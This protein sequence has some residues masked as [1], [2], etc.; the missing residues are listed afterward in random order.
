MES[1][2]QR[3]EKIQ[4][5]RNISL[6][7][8]SQIKDK[9]SGIIYE[10]R[11]MDLNIPFFIKPLAQELH[12]LKSNFSPYILKYIDDFPSD[13]YQ[14]Y[15]VVTE[16]APSSL[17][18][19]IQQ[20]KSQKKYIEEDFVVK[21]FLQLCLAIGSLHQRRIIIRNLSIEN[22]LLTQGKDVRLSNFFLSK[23]LTSENPY[24]DMKCGSFQNQSPEMLDGKPYNEKTDIWSLG[25]I[26]YELLTLMFPF[27]STIPQDQVMKAIRNG[28]YYPINKSMTPEVLLILQSLL[29]PDAQK[30]P[31]IKD[32]LNN[33]FLLSKASS[34]GLLQE[35]N[36]FLSGVQNSSQTIGGNIPTP[37]SILTPI[38]NGQ[39]PSYSSTGTQNPIV[40]PQP[41]P[42]A[43][44]GINEIYVTYYAEETG[45]AVNLLG[46]DCEWFNEKNCIIFIDQQEIQFHKQYKFQQ[47]GLH[48]MKLLKNDNYHLDD[49]SNMFKNCEDI[50]EIDGTNWHMENVE[51]I[52]RMFYGCRKLKKLNI[53]NWDTHNIHEMES[54]FEE[55][56]CLEHLNINFWNVE[57]VRTMNNLFYQ[58]FELKEM[59]LPNW[60]TPNLEEM[61]YLFCE[62]K[63]L[64]SVDVSNFKVDLVKNFENIFSLCRSLNY[65][66]LSKWF[67]INAE[68]CS[69]MF[70]ECRTLKAV[71]LSSF[72]ADN[73]YCMSNM[74]SCCFQLESVDVSNWNTIKLESVN[75]MFKDCRVL[76]F[77]D[78]FNWKIGKIDGKSDM[79]SGCSSLQNR[80]EVQQYLQLDLND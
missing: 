31:F 54:V 33:Q 15:D 39:G 71:N 21:I 58:C 17:P 25:L 4:K 49:L 73:I 40:L 34:L 14:K 26:F 69:H 28:K 70:E 51:R 43:Q 2:I 60:V 3:Y 56:R 38:Q 19:L 63:S 9:K 13:N 44:Q 24:S 57:N 20:Y 23:E 27:P 32:L 45:K 76:K 1:S 22:V 11:E 12:I 80:R 77:L 46:E 74:F 5:V 72:R 53:S 30:R 8:V 62:C 50:V 36:N 78:V 7:E 55:C 29:C 75:C 65:I 64:K 68:D 18:Q 66:D 48:Q 52:N 37:S 47:K 59:L 42:P 16:P 79:I 35:I 61:R 41:L 10:L 6:V 67:T